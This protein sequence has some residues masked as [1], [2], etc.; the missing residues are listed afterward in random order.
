M[1]PRPRAI[2]VVS[3]FLFAASVVAVLVA[4]SLL[5]P[6]S[7]LDRIWEL[8]K[9]AE[10][11]FRT[12]GRTAGVMLLVLGGV[13]CGIA[14][15]LLL[16]QR[17]AL[18]FAIALFAINGCGDVASLLITR[19]WLRVVGGVAVAALFIFVLLDVRVRRYFDCNLATTSRFS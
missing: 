5:F 14:I 9:P 3:G 1:L 13:S 19:D 7:P 16:R 4:P 12:V 8:N 17:W 11:V 2:A 6:T 15:G 18:W 10:R